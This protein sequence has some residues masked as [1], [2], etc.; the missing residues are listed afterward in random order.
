MPRSSKESLS[1]D[2][3][4]GQTPSLLSV[5]HASHAKRAKQKHSERGSGV[6]AYLHLMSRGG[7][8]GIVLEILH[9]FKSNMAKEMRERK[10]PSCCCRT[11]MRD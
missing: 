5:M 2:G 6:S 7:E 4:L 11:D 8:L 1:S 10:L 9:A 3:N